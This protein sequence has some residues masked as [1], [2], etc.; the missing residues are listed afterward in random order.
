MKSPFA[1]VLSFL[2]YIFLP[3]LFVC[4]SMFV[5]L[6]PTFS[7]LYNISKLL[8]I[9]AFLLLIIVMFAKAFMVIATPYAKNRFIA[10]I[11][12]A[13][14]LLT[15]NRRQ[16]GLCTFYFA[17]AHS[18]AMTLILQLSLSDFWQK[19]YLAGLIAAIALLIGAVT[20]NNYSVKKLKKH[21]KKVQAVSYIAL[22]A[23]LIH[24]AVLEK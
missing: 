10:K 19:G 8:G 21:W 4:F 5:I 6:F 16:L 2:A 11:L 18:I 15:A 13:L 23:V 7:S 3:F 1:L 24:I 20:S 14:R 22:F 17:M 12:P 9:I